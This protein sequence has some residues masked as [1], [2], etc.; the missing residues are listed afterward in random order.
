LNFDAKPRRG[1][2]EKK[3]LFISHIGA[4]DS[5]A[6]GLK[7]AYRIIDEGVMDDF[8]EERYSSFNNEEIGKKIM[9]SATNFTELEKYILDKKEILPSSGR[10][11]KLERLLNEYLLEF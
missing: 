5:F 7:I 4:M 11:E 1:S 9:N 10:Q 3:D 2:Y 6:A 8:I